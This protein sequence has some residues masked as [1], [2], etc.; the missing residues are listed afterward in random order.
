MYVGMYTI[1]S[2]LVDMVIFYISYSVPHLFFHF[3]LYIMSQ[4]SL[5][6][7]EGFFN[8]VCVAM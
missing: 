8:P 4:Q 2:P 5:F 6:A 1:F 7:R 3:K